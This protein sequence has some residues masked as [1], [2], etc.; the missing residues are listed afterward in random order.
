M[1]GSL[2]VVGIAILAGF[3][4]SKLIFRIK[5]PSVAA[6]VLIGVLLGQ[7]VLNV[8]HAD[9]IN[10]VGVIN[11]IALGLIAFIIGGELRWTQLKSLGKSIFFIVFFEA[12][13]AFAFV[14]FLVQIIFKQWELSL[15]LG[16]IAS[17]TAPAATVMV[18]REMRAE[19]K[20]TQTLLSVVAIDDGI[21]LL[22][23][24]FAS[25][26]AKVLIVK[27]DHFSVHG[28][29]L[30]AFSEIIFS[31]LIGVVAGY[32]L[33]FLIKRFSN[34]K[35]SYILTIGTLFVVVGLANHLGYSS[36]LANLAL[37][38]VIVNNLPNFSRRIFSLLDDLTPPIFIAFFVTA[39]AH[40]RLDLIPQIW[41]LAIV[42]TIARIIGKL[43]GASLGA[44]L[45]NAD[46][47]I[48]KY[49]GFGLISQVGVAIGLALVVSREFYG[50][51]EAGHHFANIIINLLL[52]T[53]IF[54]EIVGPILTRYALIKSGDA[55][56]QL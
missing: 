11:D 49:M 41:W 14:T 34:R 33:S 22:I 7:S 52:T 54:T 44:S 28:V 36:L 4:V 8:F 39:G 40:L 23:Y 53:T 15:M 56:V 19:G 35:E 21:A 37:G 29:L 12:F 1:L 46:S 2:E 42:Y 26:I 45:S 25:A 6:Y 38:V 30:S 3:F 13:G 48:K 5:I 47:S 16:A 27:T 24:S 17:A 20:F 9:M 55:K 32:I 10:S 31:I 18:I 50:L 51:G 43:L